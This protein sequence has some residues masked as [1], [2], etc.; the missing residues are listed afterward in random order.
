MPPGRESMPLGREHLPVSH[1]AKAASVLLARG[2]SELFIVR[3][4]EKLRFFGGFFA[5]AGG[6][7]APS[8]RDIPVTALE[9]DA[10]GNGVSPDRYVAAAREL[11]EETGALLARCGDGSFPAA[12]PVLDYL[13]RKM[14]AENQPFAQVLAHLGASIHATDFLPLGRV[15]T[16][17][18]VPIRYDTAFFFAKLPANQQPEVWPGELDHGE[19]ARADSV[20][21]RWTRG[22]CLVSP[23]TIAIL[24]A[25]CNRGAEEAALNLA[26]VFR[27]WDEGAIHPIYFAPQVQ[28]IPLH[29]QGL[30][31]STH[32]NAYLI[33]RDPAYLL[34]PGT[35]YPEEQQRLFAVLD[36]FQSGGGRLTAVVLTHHH[37]DHI[38]AA[39]AC[40][41][42][43]RLPIYAHP[44]TAE[45]LRG[46]ITVGRHI[47][48]GDRLD[49]GTAPDRSGPWHLEAIHTPG[50]ASGHLAFYEPHYRLLFAG[51]M[52][53]TLS[54]V[55]IAPPDGDLAV[56]LRS[57]ERL[58][59]YDCRLLLPAHGS[60]SAQPRQTID[61]C[62]AHRVR[63]EEQ[64]L[65][66]LST[67]PRSIT[68][69]AQDLYK[70]LPP[71]MMLFAE[72]QVRAGLRKL[73]DEG[74][75]QKTADDGELWSK[76]DHA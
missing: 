36:A 15:V 20:L 63:R 75:A 16:P 19:W 37:P 18:F 35:G 29:T 74:Q 32:T 61:E 28:L 9:P 10:K 73:H 55:V 26:T 59:T 44:L 40:A 30:P 66:A 33:G 51:D 47:D 42:R 6:K 49:L 48:D 4:A 70:G 65:A 60:A 13:R 24:S 23:P 56:Y 50:H 25:F 53:S 12:G 72:L 76:R 43:Y 11:F 34:D 22:E 68:D 3:R 54:S 2:S 21:Q 71:Q 14:V 8:D 46:Q 38:G 69:L 52:V 45:T 41:A 5:F 27:S 58:R 1:I 64:L 39:N 17:D 7:V 31:P 62:I 67:G 57:L